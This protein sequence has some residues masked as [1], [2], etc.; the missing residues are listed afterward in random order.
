MP[1]IRTLLMLLV[2]MVA[3]STLMAAVRGNEA[4]Y[5]GGTITTVPEKTEGRLDTTGNT[6]ATF[7]AKKGSF[8]IPYATIT[9]IEYGQKAG[10]RVGVALAIS[11]IALFSKKRKH[12]LSIAYTDD[13]GVKQGA[14]FE[15]AKGRVRDVAS[16]LESKSG[17][18]IEFESEDAKKHYEGK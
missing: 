7:T 15:I 2:S 3:S 1:L 13:K 18:Q 11:P 14:V 10:R 16:V 12:F 6:Q 5:V 4:M 17:K 8:S 9:S